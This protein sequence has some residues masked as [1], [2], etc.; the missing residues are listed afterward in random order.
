[1]AKVILLN[2]R[3]PE[4]QL[5]VVLLPFRM[6][7]EKIHSKRMKLPMDNGGAFDS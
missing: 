4:S 3:A 6:G 2:L 5:R 1:M 7:N